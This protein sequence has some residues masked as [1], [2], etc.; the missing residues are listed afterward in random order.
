MTISKRG[1][2]QSQKEKHVL[3]EKSHLEKKETLM[4]VL[5]LRQYLVN[6]LPL[7]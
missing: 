5:G 2:E 4:D 3:G 1:A 7:L 6:K